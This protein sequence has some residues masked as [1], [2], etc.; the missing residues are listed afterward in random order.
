MARIRSTARSD[1]YSGAESTGETR[2]TE[3]IS[4]KSSLEQASFEKV[5]KNN[6]EA[7]KEMIEEQAEEEA[8]EEAEIEEGDDDDDND[9]LRPRKAS[10]LVFGRSN[11]VKKDFSYYK[12]VGFIKDPSRCRCPGNEE[13]PEPRSGEIILF[14]H[15]FEA[16][17][18]LPVHPMVPKVMERFEIFFH[19]LTPNAFVRLGVYIWIL[20]SQGL[21]PNLE[22]FCRTHELHYQTKADRKNLLH[23]NFGC[24]N[25]RSRKDSVGPVL[26]YRS[27]WANGWP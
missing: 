6:E 1:F 20:A 3:N 21:E 22:C 15:F 2:D 16:G 9:I 17:L 25:F 12:K 7:N 18:R 27:K 13:T 5:E 14:E 11:I 19:Q 23:P 8:A 4:L 10:H 26:A 24:Y